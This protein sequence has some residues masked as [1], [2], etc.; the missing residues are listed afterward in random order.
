MLWSQ[1]SNEQLNLGTW[2][3]KPPSA[4]D[5]PIEFNVEFLKNTPNTGA[6]FN[7]LGSKGS[8]EPPMALGCSCFFACKEAIKAARGG[9]SGYFDLEVPL[10]VERIQQ[11]CG[12]R[13]ED[14]VMT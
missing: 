4:A 5:I 9:E 1:H 13:T 10:T 3:Y 12:V 7:V 6:P 14:L 2:N 11:A 8:G